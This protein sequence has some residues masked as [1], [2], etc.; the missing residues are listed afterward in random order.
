MELAKD[1]LEQVDLEVIVKPPIESN[2]AKRKGVFGK[3]Q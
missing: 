1:F 2:Q 3:S